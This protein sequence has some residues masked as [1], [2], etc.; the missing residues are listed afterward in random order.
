L[1]QHLGELS[2]PSTLSLFEETIAKL[3]GLYDVAPAVIAHDLHPDYRS[4][5]W[6]LAQR[7]PRIVVQHHHAHIASCLAEHHRIGPVLGVAFD[8]T[9]CGPAGQLWGG[10]FLVADLGGFHRVGHLRALRLAG[11]ESAIREPWRLAA[12]ALLDVGAPLSLLS[13]CD[14]RR[15]AAVGRLLSQDKLAPQATS[16]GRWFDAF[17]ALLAV[18]DEITYEGQ[19]AI[20]LEALAGDIVADPLPFELTAEDPFVVDLRPA[21]RSLLDKIG[22]TRAELAAAVHETFAAIV[23]AAAKRI[24]KTTVALSGGCFQNARLTARCMAALAGEGFEVLVHRRVPPNDG[25][26]SLGQAAVALYRSAKE[27]ANVSRHSG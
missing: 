9:G 24:H 26:I 18:R 23:V 7:R 14:A 25:G 16:A 20:E 8:G 21:V 6:A 1:S 2:H 27:E 13:R 5:R 15:L 12:S 17:A 3:S 22:Q 19:A 10:E 4:T 11:G